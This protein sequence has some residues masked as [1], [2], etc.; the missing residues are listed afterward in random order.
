MSES[1][2]TQGDDQHEVI[3]PRET[4]LKGWVAQ[5]HIAHR[6]GRCPRKTP[7]SKSRVTTNSQLETR[8]M[9]LCKT[10]RE[11]VRCG[12]P[13][14]LTCKAHPG[15]AI[16]LL[17]PLPKMGSMDC[18]R[19]RGRSEVYA[20]KSFSMTAGFWKS[21]ILAG[22]RPRRRSIVEGRFWRKQASCVHVGPLLYKCLRKVAVLPRKRQRRIVG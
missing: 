2:S 13:R 9:L 6:Y 18:P 22:K 4:W 21:T 8:K 12:G 7:H 14:G 20:Q 16:T 3:G 19:P 17:A 11:R 15:H 5:T 1:K 10:A